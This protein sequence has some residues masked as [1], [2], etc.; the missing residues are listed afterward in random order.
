MKKMTCIVY[1]FKN[2]DGR[3]TID[4]DV[5]KEALEKYLQSPPHTKLGEL[6]PNPGN[7]Y[8]S[9]SSVSHKIDNLKI[10]GDEVVADVELLDTPCGKVAQNII[11]SGQN[12]KFEP[13]ML[14]EYLYDTDEE[15][16]KIVTGI[17]GLELLTI[18]I[19]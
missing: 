8:I 2:Q 10:K 18:D 3:Y 5:F 19:V 4:K 15:G 16:R 13:R 6:H 9:L 17:K 1:D 12:L 7:D 14:G 11:E